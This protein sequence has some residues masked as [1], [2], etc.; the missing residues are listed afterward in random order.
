MS[1]E[2]VWYSD[3]GLNLPALAETRNII[4]PKEALIAAIKFLSANSE[5]PLP[6]GKLERCEIR[7]EPYIAVAIGIRDEN[8]GQL[9]VREFSAERL[10]A[11]LIAYCH[12]VNVPLPRAAEKSLSASGDSLILCVHVKSRPAKHGHH[13]DPQRFASGPRR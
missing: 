9:H 11:A 3:P 1:K 13:L 12:R 8:S 10:A 6:H 5:Q 2:Q 7:S 4:F